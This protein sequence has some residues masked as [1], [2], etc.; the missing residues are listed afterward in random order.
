MVSTVTSLN[1]IPPHLDLA[2]AET[3]Y[4]AGRL[5]WSILGFLA[6]ARRLWPPLDS[7]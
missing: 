5:I 1:K 3:L 7:P 6:N 2:G 4:Y